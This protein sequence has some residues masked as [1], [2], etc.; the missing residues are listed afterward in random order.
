MKTLNNKTIL[1]DKYL[2]GL[3]PIAIIIILLTVSA[4]STKKNT[5]TTRAYHN[6]TARYNVYFNGNESLKSGNL[7]LKKTY[8]E[9]YSRIIP[10]FRYEDEAVA[11]LVASEMDRTIKKCAKTIKSHSITVKPKTKK[12]DISA[13]EQKFLTQTEYCKWIDNA[14]LLMGKAHFYKREFETARQTF[15]LVINKYKSEDT[16]YD[17]MLWLAKTYAEVEEYK[18]AENVLIDLRKT[19][20]YDR[21]YLLQMELIH[22]SMLLKQKDYNG[23]ALKLNSAIENEKNKKEKTRQLFIL[24]QIYQ[25]NSKFSLAEEYYKQVIKRNPNYEMTFMAKINLAEIFE[26]SGGNARELKKQLKKMAKDDKNIDYLDQIYYALGKIELNEKHEEKAIEYFI[27]SSQASSSNKTQKVKT[28]LA[29][30]EY[31]YKKE[32]FKLAEAYYDSTANSIESTFP[33]YERL[34]PQIKS[35]NEL[36]QNLNIIVTEDSLQ[37]MARMPE[38]DRNRVI[39]GIIQKIQEEEQRQ[40]EASKSN[41]G[42]FDPIFDDNRNTNTNPVQGGKHYFYNPSTISLGMTEFKK[43]WGDRKLADHWRRSNKQVSAIEENEI[44]ENAENKGVDSTHTGVKK[45]TDIK[46]REFYLQNLPLTEEKLAASNKNIENAYFK[47]ADI[48][49]KQ[50]NENEKAIIQFEKL[51]SKF[52]KSEYRLEILY[53]LY[54]IHD[55]NMN[56]AKSGSYKEMII[57]EFPES[58]YAKLLNDPAYAEKLMKS[59]KIA[60]ETYQKAYETYKNKDYQQ[61]IFIASNGLKEFPEHDLAPQFIYLTALAYG[62]M[63]NKTELKNNLELVILK[64]PEANVADNAKA[65]LDVMNAKKYEENLYS[66]NKEITHF[67]VLIFPK[68]KTDVNKLKFK[69]ISLNVEHYTQEDLQVSIQSLDPQRDMIVVQSFKNAEEANEYFQLVIINAVLKEIRHLVPSHFVISED[70][71]QN[72]LKNKDE[73]K[74]LKFFN[75]NYLLN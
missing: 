27:L 52:P 25:F 48:Y 22:A 62:G 18:N 17:A 59:Q 28:F 32:D 21:K 65:T 61:T 73:A 20:K 3:L 71:Y 15:L 42:G 54:K 36:T 49:Y 58:V 57:S 29:L 26:K 68:G 40:K 30:A 75:E 23:A 67:Y 47:S 64:F 34:Y 50:M 16:K 56:Y 31:Y 2:N 4:C 72:F 6:L 60:E 63:G 69:Y 44:T 9:D 7:K 45:V 13:K 33:D 41:N 37:F 66:A 51:M 46:K 19:K 10:V 5:G 70:N 53:N 38:K 55:K 12:K 35:R 11:S 24:A 74:Y 1:K 14:Y 39:D 8:Q 43:R